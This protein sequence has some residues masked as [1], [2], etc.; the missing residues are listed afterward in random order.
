[1]CDVTDTSNRKGMKVYRAP[2]FL[3]SHMIWVPQRDG[4]KNLKTYFVYMS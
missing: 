3:Y 2:E 4:S 1:M